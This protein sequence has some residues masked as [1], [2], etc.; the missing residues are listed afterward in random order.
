AKTGDM[1]FHFW[2]E[3]NMSFTISQTKTDLTPGVYMVSVFSQGGDMNDDCNMELYAIADGVEY[4]V[5][6]IDTSWCNWQNPIIC[7]IPIT[8]GEITFG[9][10]MNLCPKSWGTLDDF[11]LCLTD[12]VD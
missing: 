2:S 1:S 8:D 5:S 4:T 10:R 3:D 12:T 6:F 9:V 11:S 7:D